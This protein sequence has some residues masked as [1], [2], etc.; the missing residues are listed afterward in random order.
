[1]AI[2]GMLTNG[3]SAMTSGQ[4]YK[5]CENATLY[6]LG[7]CRFDDVATTRPSTSSV[8]EWAC[9]LCGQVVSRASLSASSAQSSSDQVYI[10]PVGIFKAHA[11]NG[12]VGVWSCIWQRRTEACSRTFIERCNFL[13]HLMDVHVKTQSGNGKI[14][15]DLPTDDREISVARCGYGIRKGGRE[16][17]L[18]DG[19]FIVNVQGR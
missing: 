9:K 11:T 7:L 15:V 13:Q 2:T 6:R 5:R 17:Q 4:S 10:T 14:V 1:M 19:Q 3:D 12:G 16:M 8:Q 18:I